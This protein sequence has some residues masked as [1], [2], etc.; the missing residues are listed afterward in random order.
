LCAL[1]CAL[2]LAAGLSAS[3]QVT[4]SAGDPVLDDI[5]YVAREAGVSVLS[6]TPPLSRDEIENILAEVN[7]DRLSLPAREAL[8]RI[9]AR[10][11]PPAR[12]AEDFFAL[13]FQAVV[14]AEAAIRSN[15]ALPWNGAAYDADAYN[16][17]ASQRPALLCFPFDFYFADVVHLNLEPVVNLDPAFTETDGRFLTNVP[18]QSER[19]DMFFPFRAFAAAGGDWWHFQIGRDQVSFGTAH[20]GNLL[21]SDTPD[22]YD[23]A[24]LS[25]FSRSFKYSAMVIQNP[26][27]LSPPYYEGESDLEKSMQRY[28]YIHRIDFKIGD[29]FAAS[30]TEGL[31]VGNAPLELRYLNPLMIMHNFMSGDDY[32]EW[33]S[34]SY[35][36][37]GSSIFSV[38]V[39]WTPRPALSFYAQMVI[40]EV[41][42]PWEVAS[43]AK[44]K[45]PSGMGYLAGIEYSHAFG[46]W[47][48][49]F[50][51]EAAYTDP[52]LY[53]DNSPFAAFVWARRMNRKSMDFRYRWMGH[54]EGRDAIVFAAGSRFSQND[55]LALS[56]DL[57]YVIHGEHGIYWDWNR[58]DSYAAEKTPTG[59]PEK[60]LA[61]S[62]GVDWK[63]FPHITLSAEIGGSAAI[64]ANHT[65][66]DEFGVWAR[67]G[68]MYVF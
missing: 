60:R 9:E 41:T 5:R 52:Y 55:R 24:R 67:L 39:N 46:A 61:A 43:N 21:L 58:G 14:Q 45:A 27:I 33:N 44:N 28:V 34:V 4:V 56:A 23:F 51:G 10:L 22:Y 31:S 19:I 42:T 11:N 49:Q 20:T 68:V 15:A 7:A 54:P 17:A 63:P 8:G 62:L 3:P 59:T 50:Y 6:F 35:N 65:T 12:F 37:M 47:G 66:H 32:D 36:E 18:Y 48:A 40:D 26:L 53:V 64:N 57:S 16:G 25:L 2:G 1:L 30:L 13:S 38:E 29:T